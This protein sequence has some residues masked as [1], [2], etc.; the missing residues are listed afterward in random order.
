MS[1]ALRKQ[2]SAGE[3]YGRLLEE[4]RG[5]AAFAGEERGA[6]A[7]NEQALQARWFEQSFDSASLR[8]REGHRVEVVSPGWWNRQAGPDFRGAQIAFNGELFNGDVEIHLS[9]EGW[10]AHGHHLDR[11]YDEVILHVVLHAPEDCASVE[12]ASGR[13]I[14]LLVLSEQAPSDWDAP[15]DDDAEVLPEKACGACSAL[16]PV[17]GV[18]PLKRA[19]E[20]AGEWR[21]LAKARALE[22]RMERIGADQALHEA[23]MAAAGYGAF[24]HHFQLMARQLPIDRAVQLAHHDPLLLEA[25]LLHLGGLLPEAL[26]EGPP[27][28]HHA[29]LTALRREHLPGLK[30]LPLVWNRA[31]LRPANFPERRLGGMARVIARV[32]RDGLFES[33]MAVWRA[34]LGDRP[35]REAFARLFPNAMGFWAT[36]YTWQ[37]KRLERPVAPI[38]A[39]RLH[40][41][42]GNV[43]V[44]L[45]FTVARARKDRA[46][47]E[48]VI[49]FYARFPKESD[50]HIVARMQPKLLGDSGAR[51]PLRFQLQQGMLQFHQ[52]WCGPNPSCRNCT[53]HRYLDR[54]ERIRK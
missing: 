44:P 43:F 29:R 28:P 34:G 3:P 4:S 52:D 30:P 53:M 41:I 1:A 51:L 17:Q 49:G 25:A 24:K 23:L 36:H 13:S 38:G 50:N 5:L 15:W 27:V 32:A 18:A 45:A 42:I 20:L 11:R 26:P 8:T 19:L 12:T 39:A 10:K 46:L 37:G 40:S 2:W 22:S 47:E 9:P 31:G 35:T 33:V 7:P 14:P 21:L 48:R 6:G 16:I 54:G